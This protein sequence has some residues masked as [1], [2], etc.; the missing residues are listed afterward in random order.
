MK[1]RPIVWLR[2]SIWPWDCGWRGLIF[3]PRVLQTRVTT[4]VTN[5]FSLSLWRVSGGIQNFEYIFYKRTHGS[6]WGRFGYGG[7]YGA[8][9]T[10]GTMSVFSEIAEIVLNSRDIQNI[11]LICF[12]LFASANKIIPCYTVVLDIKRYSIWLE[13]HIYT[14]NFFNFDSSLQTSRAN[15]TLLGNISLLRS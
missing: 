7:C 6:L 8:L 4:S 14:E 12:E 11:P 15:Y 3:T 13:S 2:R 5:S 10:T 1:P 9:D